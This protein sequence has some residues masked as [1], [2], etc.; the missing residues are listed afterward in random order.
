MAETRAAYRYALALLETAVETKAVEKVSKDFEMVEALMKSSRDFLLFLRSP[1]VNTQ[2]KKSIFTSL[3]KDRL[4]EITLKF[5]LLLTTKNRET[6]LP[7]IIQQY[8]RLRDKRLG[9]E[10]VSVRSAVT[11]TKE[12]EKK[13]AARLEQITKK[14]IRLHP[15]EDRQ[16]KGGLTVQIG[17]TVWDG[18][19]VHQ[20]ELLRE[21][22]TKGV[23]V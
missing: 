17:D 22:F 13:L 19:V 3:L 20:L 14:K 10:N 4:D 12:Q 23:H 1:V 15:A 7:E 2:K 18:S 5:I 11:L 6:I 8:Y 9:I 21:R 16:L